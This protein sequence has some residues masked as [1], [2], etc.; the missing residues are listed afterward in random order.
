MDTRTDS[1]PVR[2]LETKG[3]GHFEEVEW[4]LPALKPNQIRVKNIMTGVCRSD[5]DM[6][7][8]NFGPLPSHMQGH[9]GLGQVIAIGSLVGDVGV[10]SYVAT[11]GEPAYADM[12]NCDLKTYVKVP[13]PKPRYIIEPVACAINLVYNV[14]PFSWVRTPK[15]AIY[16]SGFLAW[17]VYNYLHIAHMVSYDDID[18]FGS[19]NAE[20]WKT[21]KVELRSQPTGNKYDVIIDLAG[22]ASYL[23]DDV[24]E[25]GSLVIMGSEKHP[26]ASTTFARLL[27]NSCKMIFPSPRAEQFHH[28]MQRAV[29]LVDRMPDIDSFW[30]KAY[31]RESE[32]HQAFED[33]VNRPKGYGRGYIVW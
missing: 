7:Q 10:G 29:W 26:P 31:N 20:I 24:F 4:L 15:I 12:Y 17:V 33:G 19:S 23:N 8:G 11:R 13:E 3:Q 21:A 2:L 30:T 27:W 32:W 9:E 28:C 1:V 18:V 5:I 22:N 16:G 14:L 25:P 6:M